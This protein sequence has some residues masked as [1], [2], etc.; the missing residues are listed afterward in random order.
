MQIVRRRDLIVILW[1][2]RGDDVIVGTSIEI[3]LT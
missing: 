2:E 1:K 3:Y